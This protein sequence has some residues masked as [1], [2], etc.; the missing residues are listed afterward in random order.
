MGRA[1]EILTTDQHLAKLQGSFLIDSGQSSSTKRAPRPRDHVTSALRDLHWLPIRH[2]V[3]YKLCV[4]MHQV[5]I[6]SSPSYLSDLVTATANIQL[7]KRLRSADTN[8]HEPFTTRL[9]FGERCFSHAGPKAWTALPADL[10]DLT[11]HS[12][13]KRQLK[14]FLFERAFTT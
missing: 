5:H 10:Q 13:F 9:K 1:K 14:T 6:G 12:A 4:L 11:D 8:R 7:R 2:R 3:T